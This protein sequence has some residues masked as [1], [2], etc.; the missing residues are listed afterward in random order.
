ME[1]EL[2]EW[3]RAVE[4]SR[5][6]FYQLN[7]YTTLQLLM[8]REELGKLR[9]GHHECSIDPGPMTLLMSISLNVTPPAV[10]RAVSR[11]LSRTH[12]TMDVSAEGQGDTT[13]AASPNSH[14]DSDS[15]IAAQLNL[16]KEERAIYAHMVEYYG[17]MPKLVLKALQMYGN[18][19]YD[20]ENWCTEHQEDPE[21]CEDKHSDNVEDDSKATTEKGLL[22]LD[23][24]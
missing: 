3:K 22:K 17:F 4:E 8:L 11:G 23:T 10:I 15:A 5:D 18:D 1:D 13:R 21:Y 6:Q 19:Q 24:E 7:Y 9:N 16:S 2:E 12:D 14:I 20:V